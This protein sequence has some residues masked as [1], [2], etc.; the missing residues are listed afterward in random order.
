MRKH[1]TVRGIT[2][3]ILYALKLPVVNHTFSVILLINSFRPGQY[4]SSPHTHTHAHAHTRARA[5]ARAH[6]HTHTHTHTH[7]PDLSSTSVWLY[8]ETPL[9][10]T[11]KSQILVQYGRQRRHT[12]RSSNTVSDRRQQPQPHTSSPFVHHIPNTPTEQ[13]KFLCIH[14]VTPKSEEFR[15]IEEKLLENEYWHTYCRTY[16]EAQTCGGGGC[17]KGCWEE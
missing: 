6:A 4:L 2:W 11:F 9:P 10:A 8:R 17:G 7:T 5:H 1:H 3:I 15:P 14:Y 12:D 13:Q 16:R